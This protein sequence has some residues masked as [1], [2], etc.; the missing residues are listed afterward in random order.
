[1]SF[2]EEYFIFEDDSKKKII[3]YI[4]NEQRIVIPDGV[5]TIGKAAF[6]SSLALKEVKFNNEIKNIDN[7][8]F[9]NCINLKMPDTR[10][11]LVAEDA[12]LNCAINRLEEITIS[13]INELKID[14]Y[15]RSYQR[16]YRWTPDELKDL[17]ND[18]KELNPNEKYC[19]QPLTVKRTKINP[20][21]KAFQLR[22]DD[23]YNEEITFN[24][25]IDVFELIDGQQRL[26][27]IW[28]ILSIL[29]EQP[30][31][32]I[33]YETLR[34]VDR[35][36]INDI[37]KAIKDY[38][39][40]Q[41]ELINRI[42]NQLIFIWYEV[43]DEDPI[44][45]FN[46]IN[47]GQIALTNAELFKALLLNPENALN[48]DGIV[49]PYYEQ[50]LLRICFE[51]DNLEQRLHNDK[52]WFF[53][54]KDKQNNYTRIDYLLE[55]YAKKN[56]KRLKEEK[57]ND[58]ITN[59]NPYDLRFSFI[60]TKGL[61]KQN[62]SKEKTKT[63]HEKHTP[64]IEMI[65]DIWDNGV[66]AIYNSLYSWYSDDE[67]FHYVGFLVA[68][69]SKKAGTGI[70]PE[71]IMNL[72]CVDGSLNEI[73]AEARKAVFNRLKNILTGE[74]SIFLK[75]CYN[76]SNTKDIVAFLLFFNVWTCLN[77]GTRFPFDKFNNTAKRAICPHCYKELKDLSEE[78]KSC[79]FCQKE[80][81]S[82]SLIKDIGTPVKWDVEHIKAKKLK[83]IKESELDDTIKQW[84]ESEYPDIL[85]NN[86]ISIEKYNQFA[87]NYT[88]DHTISNL[89]LLDSSTNRSYGND[90]FNEKR[91]EIIERDKGNIYIPICTKNV[92]LKYYNQ[93]PDTTLAWTDSDEESYYEAI[94]DC[95]RYIEKYLVYDEGQ[96][97]ILKQRIG[98]E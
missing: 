56:Q 27:T 12:F 79:R 15:V 25:E 74:K 88:S 14:F 39:V 19:M 89:V 29:D 94:K 98:D 92:F 55:A 36:F 2:S 38:Q 95:L 42:K 10:D 20:G 47:D 62:I 1:M 24:N 6:A 69:E 60:F 64:I 84:L 11:A 35:S 46:S 44:K 13:K 52:L 80:I 90:F 81:D 28:L 22:T 9:F 61:L 65:K 30:N 91:I 93:N 41:E 66:V 45:K 8:A 83:E 50:S 51:W 43:V 68:T 26:T 21:D 4:G 18:I 7:L 96:R 3:K 70:V 72:L 48:E 37:R 97:D 33:Y 71:V 82:K 63:E 73:R 59:L 58:E 77:A 23:C 78:E 34:N 87:N 31:Y 16:G 76:E 40:N 67:L 5:E 49:D 32:S 54:S 53:L 86:Q 75:N 17:L 85:E 57:N